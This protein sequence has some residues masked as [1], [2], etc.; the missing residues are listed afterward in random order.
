MKIQIRQRSIRWGLKMPHTDISLLKLHFHPLKSQSNQTTGAGRVS[1]RGLFVRD[2][3]HLDF[4]RS[5]QNQTSITNLE[6]E[7]MQ[8]MLFVQKTNI[9][10]RKCKK[11]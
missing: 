10:T 7:G 11:K 9:G 5:F 4:H 8:Q 3:N 1:A 2:A 6:M